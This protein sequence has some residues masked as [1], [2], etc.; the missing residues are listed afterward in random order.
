MLRVIFKV[1]AGIGV[2]KGGEAAS[3]LDEPRDD[4]AKHLRCERE[5]ATSP[6]MRTDRIVVLT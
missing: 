5:L 2:S 3:V 6:R 1:I 4:L